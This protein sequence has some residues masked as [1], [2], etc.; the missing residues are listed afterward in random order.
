MSVI[1]GVSRGIGKPKTR[2]LATLVIP[3][4]TVAPVLTDHT[5]EHTQSELIVDLLNYLTFML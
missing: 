2:D 4:T 1:A 5:A 3:M